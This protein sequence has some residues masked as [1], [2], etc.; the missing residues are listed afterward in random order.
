M[1][2]IDGQGPD[3]TMAA[4]VAMAD[5]PQ[6]TFIA[7]DAKVPWEWDSGGNNRFP[8]GGQPVPFSA[9]EFRLHQ[10]PLPWM[11]LPFSDLPY[12][13][14]SMKGAERGCRGRPSSSGA[15]RTAGLVRGTA[16]LRADR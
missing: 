10:S 7:A 16:P 8:K 6:A 14:T 1:V 9:N 15:F 4:C 11:D 2:L 13:Q 3:M 12:W 5:N